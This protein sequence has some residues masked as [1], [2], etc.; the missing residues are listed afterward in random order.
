MKTAYD[1]R[2]AYST[3]FEVQVACELCKRFL[4]KYQTC[5]TMPK[6]TEAVNEFCGQLDALKRKMEARMPEWKDLYAVP[7]IFEDSLVFDTADLYGRKSQKARDVVR[8]LRIVMRDREID[9]EVAACM[10]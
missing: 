10:G 1:V 9:Q 2:K 4:D 5:K 3:W 8:A 7:G 6:E